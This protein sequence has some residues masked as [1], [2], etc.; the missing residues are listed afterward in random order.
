MIIGI[1]LFHY[2]IEQITQVI[3]AVS[4]FNLISVICLHELQKNGRFLLCNLINLV[5]VF[6][7][8]PYQRGFITAKRRILIFNWRDTKHTFAGGAEVYIH[9]LAKRWVKMGYSVTQFCGNDGI[10]PHNETVDGVQ[11][12]R[13]GGFY[14]VYFWAF[15]YYVRHFRGKYD[16]I[17]DTQNGIPF[18]TPLYAKESS[19]CLMFHVHQE[20]FRKSLSKHMALLASVLENRMMPWVYRKIKFITISES[21]M[22]EI[23]DLD[24]GKIGIEIIHPG[25]DLKTY[26]PTHKKNIRPLIVYIGRLQLYKSVDVLI[27]SA[28]KIFASEPD[29]RIV[30]AGSGEERGRLEHL[31]KRLRLK[32]KITFLGKITEKEKIKLYQKAWVAVN[33]SLKEGWGITTI[34]A[35]A[36]GT[37]VVASDVPGLR[38][39]VRNPS[40]GFLVKYGSVEGFSNKILQLLQD[41]FLRKDME[42]KSVTWA[43]Q[44]DWQESAEKT[45]RVLF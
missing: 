3:F 28:K 22:Q 44:F 18:F 29:A 42:K 6:N 26:K 40:T 45:V 24:L 35:N 17:I 31:V 5:D 33:P 4:I 41:E 13:R 30:I 34:E 1:F 36:C 19:Y 20:V 14:F 2:D 38:D 21:S 15:V 23:S 16:V 12:I 7:S 39:S 27:N 9:E 10:S 32:G 11:V 25:V 37:P 8:L 43:N